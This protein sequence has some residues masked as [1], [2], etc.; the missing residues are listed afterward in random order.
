[1]SCAS[2]LEACD[3]AGATILAER[4]R[5]EGE[6][7]STVVRPYVYSALSRE[8]GQFYLPVNPGVYVLTTLPPEDQVGGPADFAVIDAREGSPEVEV[9]VSGTPRV[10]VTRGTQ[11]LVGHS[12]RLRLNNFGSGARVL[13]YDLGSWRSQPLSLIHI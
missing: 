4:L 1:M 10:D 5:I 2:S 12:V 13:P 11:L 8:D 6:D 7:P 3:V 9:S